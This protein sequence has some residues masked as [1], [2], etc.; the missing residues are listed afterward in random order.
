[1]TALD[2]ADVTARGHFLATEA[3][4]VGDVREGQGA[5]LEDLVAVQV[6]NGNLGSTD[7]PQ[8]VFGIVIDVVGELRQLAGAVEALLLD[9]VRWIDLSVAVLACV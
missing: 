1:M 6:G 8:V 7:H 2:A 4:G 9:Q 5:G 3:R